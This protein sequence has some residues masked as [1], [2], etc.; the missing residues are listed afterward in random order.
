MASLVPQLR[1]FL[2]NL[3]LKLAS[4]LKNQ[5]QTQMLEGLVWKVTEVAFRDENTPN[6][7]IFI[8]R[9]FSMVFLEFDI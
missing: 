1:M 4:P 5:K 8:I 6:S 7:G 2:V 3:L 9:E